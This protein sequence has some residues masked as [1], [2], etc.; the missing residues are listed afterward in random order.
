MKPHILVLSAGPDHLVREISA[1]LEEEGV[2]FE[3]VAQKSG[4]ALDLAH[5]AAQ[6]SP[7]EVGV[8]VD[9]TGLTI[10]HHA[11][12]PLGKPVT[13]TRAARR[14]GQNAARLVI[15]APLSPEETV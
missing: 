6:R 4:A 7:L 10:V 2:P 12:L 8:G 15:G 14:A 9:A 11:K 1:G 3:I 5:R 13:Q